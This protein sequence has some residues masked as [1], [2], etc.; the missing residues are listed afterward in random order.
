MKQNVLQ[1]MIGFILK[2]IYLLCVLL[3]ILELLSVSY[4]TKLLM[5]QTTR[6]V[7]QSVSGEIS[8]RIDGILRLLTGMSHDNHF[9]DR[10]ISLF[11]RATQAKAYQDNYN[12]FMLALTDENVNV[13][14]ADEIKPSPPYSLAHRDYMQ[15]LYSTGKYQ[16]TDVFLAGSDNTTLNYT[17]AVPIFEEEKVVGSVFGSIYFHDIN[18]ILFRNIEEHKGRYFYLLDSNR[19]FMAGDGKEDYGKTLVEFLRDSQRYILDTDVQEIALAMEEHRGGNF[20]EWGSDGL[21][22][23]IYQPVELTNW[24]LM[25]RVHF[26]AVMQTLLPI[27]IGK[28]LFYILM[29]VTIHWLGR[30]YMTNSL[31]EVNHL[32]DIQKELFQSEHA[33]YDSILELT[34][35]GLTDQLTGLSTRAVLF[36]QVMQITESK[37]ARGAVVFVDLDNL[38]WINDTFGHEAGDLAIIHFANTLKQYEQQYN[39]IAARYGGDEFILVLNT[40]EEKIVEQIVK[41]LCKDLNT[42]IFVRDQS[43][44]IHGSIGVSFYPEHGTKLEDLICKADLALYSA[45][46]EGKNQMAFYHKSVG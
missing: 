45:K 22:Y 15:R 28:I 18:N 29:C 16:V 8:S 11:T 3:I 17:I 43:F 40:V 39:A 10:N 9:T 21:N 41:S 25:Y 46:Q 12:L 1:N 24:T 7:M 31:S 19:A 38:K 33:N 4:T 44:I 42:F 30:R 2:Y 35:R 26:S 36:K 34:E 37:D 13:V 6:G 32:L 20:W 23:I 14:S 27:L 5:Q